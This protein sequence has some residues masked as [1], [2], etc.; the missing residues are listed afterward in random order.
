MA[1]VVFCLFPACNKRVD[2]PATVVVP[3]PSAEEAHTN[4]YDPRNA[5]PQPVLHWPDDPRQPEPHAVEAR[6]K[7][8]RRDADEILGECQRAANG[9]WEQWERATAPYRDALKAKL[10]TLNEFTPQR[11]PWLDARFP[12]LLGKND[13]P[14]VEVAPREFLRHLVNPACYD[15]LRKERPIHIARRWLQQQGIDLIFVAVPKMSEVYPDHMLDPSPPDGIIA[16]HVRRMLLDLLNDDI[17]VVDGLPLFRELRDTDTEYLYNTADAHWAPRA[18]RIMAKEV[19]DRIARYRFGARARYA[20]PIVKVTPGFNAIPGV[21]MEGQF[22]TTSNQYGWPALSPEQQQRALAAQTTC[23]AQVT[24]QNE[25][26]LPDDSE[27]PVLV[28][29]NSFVPQFNHQLV[30]ELN[31]LVHTRWRA[32][33]STE[34]FFD[35]LRDPALLAHRRVVVWVATTHHLCTFRPMPKEIAASLQGK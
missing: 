24:L 32:A 25:R 21:P 7:I 30:K 35:F 10:A 4:L 5:N 17:E 16:P 20:L 26:G 34:V 31:L 8:M 9:D 29:G 23:L 22:G 18:M 19:A 27:S 28:M 11:A 15:S 3:S 33:A 2:T 12:P 1:T 13:F 6:G 14:L